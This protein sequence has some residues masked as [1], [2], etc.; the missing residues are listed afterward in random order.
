M[1]REMDLETRVYLRELRQ[2]RRTRERLARERD[3]LQA[4]ADAWNAAHP[5]RVPV[6]VTLDLGAQF[7]TFTR[8]IA[9][10]VC[11]HVSIL[12]DGISG[13][14]LLSRCRLDLSR[15]GVVAGEAARNLA[16]AYHP[17]PEATP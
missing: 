15:A 14:Y 16:A 11:D 4:E 13:G 6:V 7:P 9:W 2:A 12:V 5:P 1:T 17:N 8:S 3:R 10:I